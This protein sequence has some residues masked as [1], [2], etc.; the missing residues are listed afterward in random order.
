MKKSAAFER[1]V[2]RIYELLGRSGA[3]AKWDDHIPDPDNPSRLRQIDITVRRNGKLTMIE[4]RDRRD[5]QDV[6]WVEELSGRRLSL[7]ADVMV[8]V[9]SSGFTPGALK[10]A[11]RLGIVLCDLRSLTDLEVESWGGRVRLILYF[12]QYSDLNL[13]F[14]FEPESIPNLDM[15]AVKMD[16]ASGPYIQSLF[17]AAATRIDTLNLVKGEPSACALDFGFRAQLNDLKLSGEP[18]LEVEFKGKAQLISKDVVSPAVVAYGYPNDTNPKREAVVEKYCMG[19]TT[20]IH[21]HDRIAIFLD[22]SQLNVPPFC[23]FRYFRVAGQQEMEHYK[24]E[25]AG[26]ERVWVEGPMRI[27]ICSRQSFAST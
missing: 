2:H 20:I 24:L 8:G 12:Y 1:Q 15:Q 21:D 26:L 3:K 7:N 23:Q 4:C 5:R 10:K 6:R 17:N 16:L 18:V 19:E 11:K 13:A 25:I 14:C 27:S 9:S 22:L